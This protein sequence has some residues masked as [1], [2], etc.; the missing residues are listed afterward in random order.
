M[1]NIAIVTDTSSDITPEQAEASGVRLVPLT[2]SFGDESWEAGTE[3]RNEEFYQKLT[4]PG[5]PFPRTAA[6]NPAAFE[7][8]Y[9]EALEA[10]AD[11]VVC[12]TISKKLSATYAAAVQGAG[13]FTEGTVEVIDSE[14]T[15]HSLAMV[16]NQA[17]ALARDRATG[18][19]ITALARDL[20]LR[21]ELYFV[22]DTLECLQKGGRIGR[23]QA[24]VGTV[25][26]IKPILY[27]EDGAVAGADRK[28]TAAKARARLLELTTMRPV[29]S[30]TIVH[31]GGVDTE[32]LRA[33]FA[34][35]AKLDADAV[36]VG[37]VGPVAG[38]H[39]GPGMCGVS[40]ILT[41]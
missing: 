41:A 14:T 23:A 4:A 5:A 17:A 6:P 27:V 18:A 26:S 16:V 2:V 35:A 9:R 3:L 7:T 30:A 34:R 13:A 22:A 1:A 29:E 20:V 11:G 32:A 21:S 40:L 19:E 38:S 8:A 24:M 39:V 37:L 25:L 15:T 31:T 33:D 28:R 12:V 10:G 36:D